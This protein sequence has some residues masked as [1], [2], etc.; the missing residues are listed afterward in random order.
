M[1]TSEGKE[2]TD[3]A[4]CEREAVRE[5]EFDPQWWRRYT[6]TPTV[7][8][9]DKDTQAQTHTQTYT[10][11]RYFTARELL[12]LF[13]FPADYAFPS[14]ISKKKRYELIGNSV[15]VTVVRLVLDRLFAKAKM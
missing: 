9:T 10:Y 8:D 13:G 12:N 4:V 1:L 11:L 14:S 3:T 6:H 5:R 7:T 15:N 2:S